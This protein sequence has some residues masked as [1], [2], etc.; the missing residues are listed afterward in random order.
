MT[1]EEILDE[2]HIKFAE[3][4]KAANFN[5]IQKSAPPVGTRTFLAYMGHKRV[6]VML[7]ATTTVSK[8]RADIVFDSR[9]V[10]LSS[11]QIGNEVLKL[12]Q[13]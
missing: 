3:G 10:T 12:L 1:D 8:M 9:S 2:L 6:S 4:A 7:A 13:R 5:F 11:E